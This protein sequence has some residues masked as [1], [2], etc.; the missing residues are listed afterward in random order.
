MK[1]IFSTILILGLAING[2][3]QAASDAP[4]ENKKQ[5]LLQIK[6]EK[7]STYQQVLNDIDIKAEEEGRRSEKLTTMK[8][9]YLEKIRLAKLEYEHDL[10]LLNRPEADVSDLKKEIDTLKAKHN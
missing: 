5:E 9:D 10:K 3:A 7:L 1:Y 6:N 2:Q 4:I 8:S